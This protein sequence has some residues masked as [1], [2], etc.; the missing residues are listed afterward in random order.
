MSDGIERRRL[1]DFFF[2]TKGKKRMKH[3]N[4]KDESKKVAEEFNVKKKKVC[5]RRNKR[6]Q[7]RRWWWWW[8]KKGRSESESRNSRLIRRDSG[9]HRVTTKQNSWN[10]IYNKIKINN[11]ND[12]D[13]D[14]DYN[15]IWCDVRSDGNLSNLL[16]TG[17]YSLIKWRRF[18]LPP[19]KYTHTWL[20]DRTKFFFFFFKCKILSFSLSLSL[21]FSFHFKIRTSV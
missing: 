3:E 16:A 12:D 13:D 17:Y 15:V 18:F 8:W 4:M 20:F 2:S 6:E 10:A 11:H 21:C 14:D 7:R 5:S 9:R 19:T 1:I